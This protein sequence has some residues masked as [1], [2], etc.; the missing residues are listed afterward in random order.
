MDPHVVVH[1][2]SRQEY[3]GRHV[4]LTKPDPDQDARPL[5][6][7]S[8]GTAERE[9][10]WTYMSY[11]PFA[12]VHAMGKWLRVQARR[13]DPMFFVV[14]DDDGRH[15]GMASYLNISPEMRRLEIGH[16]WYCPD[17]QRT[18]ANTEVAY[19]LLREAFECL[20]YRRAEW[21]CDALNDTSQ[22][23]AVRLG[24]TFEGV[25]RSHM[26][27]KGRNRDTAWFSMLDSEWL[28]VRPN[29]EEW[30]YGQPPCAFSLTER[31]VPRRASG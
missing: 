29:I 19:L 28:R 10:L 11:G 5:Y 27:V 2:P 4:M 3:V 16:I 14:K 8:H 26:I 23:A 18:T 6:E 24:F 22:R 20:R 9:A 21:K 1:R 31:N 13:L 7:S 25:S 12:N 17:A 15:V 30:L